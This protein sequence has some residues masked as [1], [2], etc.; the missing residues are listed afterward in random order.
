[1]KLL[2]VSDIHGYVD[3]LKDVLIKE[4]D[5][6][7]IIFTGDI[8][9]YRKHFETINLLNKLLTIVRD[10][11][12]NYI[13]AIPGNVD[14]IHHYEQLENPIFIYLHKRYK[15]V[16]DIV[17]I[18]LGGSTI[19]PFHTMLEFS[20]EEIYKDLQSTYISYIQ[21]EKTL[22]KNKIVLVT[23]S[24]PY[25]SLCDK[26]FTGEHVGSK[27]IRSFIED[28]KPLLA[29]CGHVH[30]SRCIDKISTTTV[31]NPGPLAKGFYGTIYIGCERIDVKLNK[32]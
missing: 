32:I 2:V 3:K 19:T 27:A 9:P 28:V 14:Y 26:I 11:N 30:E 18:G 31:V 1:M 15:K 13:I 20:E 21:N 25:N 23:H 7:M 16:K 29:L 10:F 22:N 17:F 12:I 24:P 5:I 6:E 4:D 8:A